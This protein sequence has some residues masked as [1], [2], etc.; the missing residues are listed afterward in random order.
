[1]SPLS[2]FLLVAAITCFY[3]SK[4]NKK[5]TI[6][7]SGLFIIG[8]IGLIID[9]IIA[10]FGRNMYDES[11]FQLLHSKKEIFTMST[12]YPLIVVVVIFTVSVLAVIIRILF[13][14]DSSKKDNYLLAAFTTIVLSILCNT[15]YI[16]AVK[17]VVTGT[18]NKVSEQYSLN[19]IGDGSLAY[20]YKAPKITE[21]TEQRNFIFIYMEGL[22]YGYFNQ[23]KLPD[24]VPNLTKISEQSTVFSNINH[25]QGTGS[26]MTGMTASQCGIPLLTPAIGYAYSSEKIGSFLPNASCLGDL[27][28]ETGYELSY[29]GGTDAGFSNKDLLYLNHGFTNVY[30]KGE[31][32]KTQKE[33]DYSRWG[34]YDEILFKE[35]LHAIQQKNVTSNPEGIFMLTLDTHSP[36]GYPSPSCESTYPFN[37]NNDKLLDAVHCSDTLI[38]NFITEVQKTEFGKNAVIILASD[39]VSQTDRLQG[40][41][42]RLNTLII[43]D[44]QNPTGTVVTTKGTL[45]DTGITILPFLGMKGQMGLG[46]NLQLLNYANEREEIVGKINGWRKDFLYFWNI[47]STLRK[48][49]TIN[50]NLESVLVDD[51]TYQ[52]PILIGFS[53]NDTYEIN[54]PRYYGKTNFD[55]IISRNNYSEYIM[56]DYCKK[57]KDK[58]NQWNHSKELCLKRKDTDIKPAYQITGNILLE[59]SDIFQTIETAQ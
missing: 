54:L 18:Q 8:T 7:F 14:S 43:F 26:T 21:I 23:N 55:S 4:R 15:F 22:E 50:D 41:D 34:L 47:D 13:K 17:F 19:E 25:M 3:K 24:L 40:D 48:M 6:L 5:Q 11:F 35:T 29:Y 49:V 42:L 37:E 39:H 31:L 20:Y 36:N 59:K 9:A 58:K 33:Y 38:S 1:M 45:L 10:T 52:T 2:I 27:L 53:E 12:E 57:F 46:R 30:G 32:T 51:K 16:E 28:K 44:P 56:I